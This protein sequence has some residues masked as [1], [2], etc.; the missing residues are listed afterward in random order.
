MNE[1][2]KGKGEDIPNVS[3]SVKNGRTKDQPGQ[4]GDGYEEDWY[5]YMY[6]GD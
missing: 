6:N 3:D 1:Q 2:R 5:M 4:I